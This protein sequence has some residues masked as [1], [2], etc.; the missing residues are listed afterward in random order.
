MGNH[1]SKFTVYNMTT[2]IHTLDL[3]RGH[4]RTSFE[5]DPCWIIRKFTLQKYA[6]NSNTLYFMKYLTSECYIG[7]KYFKGVVLMGEDFEFFLL[8]W[9]GSTST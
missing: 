4:S 1:L 8:V 5:L 6:G 9:D 3:G 2:D 7:V